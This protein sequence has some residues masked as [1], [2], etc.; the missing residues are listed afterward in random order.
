MKKCPN[1]GH[2]SDSKFCTE[3]GSP[4]TEIEPV[5]ENF[6]NEEPLQNENSFNPEDIFKDKEDSFK[7]EIENAFSKQTSDQQSA[8][9]TKPFEKEI[10]IDQYIEE[11]VNEE[12]AKTN[13]AP[14]P[15]SDSAKTVYTYASPNTGAGSPQSTVNTNP[16]GAS[17]GYNYSSAAG[18]N[19][20]ASP[21]SNGYASSNGDPRS[22]FKNNSYEISQ[23]HGV[24]S[25]SWFVILL[26]VLFWPVGLYLMWSRKKFTKAARIII[27]VV[28]GILFAIGIFTNIMAIQYESSYTSTP[29]TEQQTAESTQPATSESTPSATIGQKNALDKAHSYLSFTAFSYTGLIDQLEY[30]GFTKEE[31]TYGADNCGADWNEQAAQKAQSYIDTMSF[32][33]QGLIEQLEFEGFTK[34]QAEYGVKAVGY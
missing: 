23:Q 30:E 11:S 6:Q 13:P 4:M 2:E 5:E 12:P 10:P 33:R 32:S 28:I 18:I 8:E 29:T 34:A 14:A 19:Q 20:N 16:A 26:L 21:Q 7:S 22:G 9:E 25:K 1:C 31:A 15:A 27:T 17:G 3:C 24:S